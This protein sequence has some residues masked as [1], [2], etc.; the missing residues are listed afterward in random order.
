MIRAIG[1]CLVFVV[2][3]WLLGGAPAPP[4]GPLM[5]GAAHFLANG[6]T[7]FAPLALRERGEG[8]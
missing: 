3:A 2:G 4:D 6:S 5:A 1:V 8:R 7:A